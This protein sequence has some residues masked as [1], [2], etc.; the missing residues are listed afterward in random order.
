MLSLQFDFKPFYSTGQRILWVESKNKENATKSTILVYYV[1]THD[2]VPFYIDR[3][4]YSFRR[5]LVPTVREIESSAVSGDS[6]VFSGNRDDMI[7]V[8]PIKNGLLKMRY[9]RVSSGE[10]D[11]LGTKW[12]PPL[13]LTEREEELVMK[14]GNLTVLGRGGT[15][16]SLVL[17]C[18][19]HRDREHS[20]DD[21]FKQVRVWEAVCIVPFFSI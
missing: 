15:G 17:C 10:I 11:N 16:K 20:R 18:R 2:K 21:G 3:I 14:S 19:M 13:R 4:D 6:G 12:K 9:V 8:D 7:L 1:S 5:R